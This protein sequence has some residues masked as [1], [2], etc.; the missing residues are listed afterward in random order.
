M[1][2]KIIIKS[3]IEYLARVEALIDKLSKR[4]GVSD[5]VYGKI[6]ISTVEAV[7]NAIIHGNKGNR[8]KNVEVVV[9]TD[10]NI[11]D[12]VITDEGKGFKYSNIPDPTKPENLEN[13]NG[14]GVFIMKK[15]ADF[16]EFNEKGNEVKMRFKY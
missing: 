4:L 11:F 14:R 5:E 8:E 7:N 2:E 12:V 1:T 10:G 13:L 3:D 16:I 6:L 15:L 9:S